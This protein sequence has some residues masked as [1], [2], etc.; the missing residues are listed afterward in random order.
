MHMEEKVIDLEKRGGQKLSDVLVT[1]GDGFIG[2]NLQEKIDCLVY[3]LTREK[4]IRSPIKAPPKRKVVHL[5]A[6][7]GHKSCAEDPKLAFD[8]NVYGTYNVLEYARK[9][10]ANVVFASTC[11][12]YGEKT[13]YSQTKIAGETLCETY[14]RL[15]DLNI[16]ILRLANVYGPHSEHK[17]SVVAKFVRNAE[18]GKPLTIE[19]DGT[20]TRD[21][22]YV[23]DVCQAILKSLDYG[24]SEAFD[25][26]TGKET[27]INELANM[28]RDLF[29][30]VEV[31]Y[32]P[33]PEYRKETPREPILVE[34]ARKKLGLETKSI[35]EGLRSW[36]SK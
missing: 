14:S 21:F 5:A 4:D 24:E 20:Q 12:V 2:S 29:D 30:D 16:V 10:D 13:E 6:I 18:N 36:L 35:E 3:D 34:D 27:S 22:I 8:T 31:R 26:G 32:V 9:N 11:G 15:Y 19:G 23:E 1:G 7:S 25:I 28:I 33:L 17:N